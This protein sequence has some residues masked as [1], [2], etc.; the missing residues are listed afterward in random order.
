[1]N[2][3]NESFVPIHHSLLNRINWFCIHEKNIY[4]MDSSQNDSIQ[5]N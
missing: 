5:L 4:E 3:Y 1:M 2:R